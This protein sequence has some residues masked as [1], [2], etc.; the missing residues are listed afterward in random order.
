MDVQ[1]ILGQNKCSCSMET[2]AR[3]NK[4]KVKSFFFHDKNV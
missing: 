4:V 3:F 1:F 2:L